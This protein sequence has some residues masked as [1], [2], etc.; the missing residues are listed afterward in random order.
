MGDRELNLTPCIRTASRELR[1]LREPHVAFAEARIELHRAS[2]MRLCIGQAPTPLQ[3]LGI[4][5]VCVGLIRRELHITAHGGKPAIMIPRLPQL[6]G[7]N[8]VGGRVLGKPLRDGAHRRDRSWSRRRERG[9][10]RRGGIA[11]QQRHRRLPQCMRARAVGEL[12]DREG[13]DS[14]RRRSGRHRRDRAVN[15]GSAL[16]LRQTR[17]DRRLENARQPEVPVDGK[18]AIEVHRGAAKEDVACVGDTLK[19]M[20]R[21]LLGRR[22]HPQSFG[23]RRRDGDLLRRDRQRQ[24]Q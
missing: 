24:A 5:V 14:L 19:E 17:H 18:R 21:R 20:P 9:V 11:R 6:I 23:G 15:C 16:G 22:R 7:E 2:V 12:P 1:D 10:K 3:Q 13:D 4:G 8:V